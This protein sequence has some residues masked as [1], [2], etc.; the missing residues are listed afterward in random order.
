MSRTIAGLLLF[1]L[2]SAANFT[3]HA[4]QE[5]YSQKERSEFTESLYGGCMD[6]QSRSDLNS[7]F[8]PAVVKDAC[9]C[10]ADKVA[11]EVFGSMEFQMA[12]HRKDKEGLQIAISKNM[13][14]DAVSKTFMAC[15]DDSIAKHGG[16]SNVMKNDPHAKLSTNVGL[17]GDSRNGYIV[18]GVLKCKT[19]QRQMPDNKGISDQ[20]IE[21]YCNC[22]VGYSAD[23][24]SPADMAEILKQ[25]PAGLKLQDKLA[26]E[27]TT[28][29][30]QKVLGNR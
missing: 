1:W 26:K 11:S 3:A 9:R 17:K 23:R 5:V 24:I 27:S 21:S 15:A 16:L 20:V 19:A 29:C 10:M 22:A 13:A 14:P 18:G 6:K 12:M 2:I 25:Q 8:L 28:F 4:A 30:R 7:Q